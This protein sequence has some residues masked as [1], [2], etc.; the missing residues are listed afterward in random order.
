M[1]KVLVSID[2]ALLER[3]DARA[4]E[5][6]LSRSAYV[7]RLAEGDVPE[8]DA[9]AARVGALARARAVFAQ[10]TPVLDIDSTELIRRMRDERTEHLASRD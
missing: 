1:A 2:D 8:G 6:G 10:A 3:I 7:S 5:L 4:R 9:R